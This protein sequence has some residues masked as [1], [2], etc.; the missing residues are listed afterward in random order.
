MTKEIPHVTVCVCTYKRPQFLKRLLSELERQETEGLFSYSVV[1]VD[2]DH[3]QSAN[4]VVSE[5]RSTSSLEIDY[6]VE[7]QQNIALARNKAVENAKG[8]FIAFIDDDEFPTKDWLATLLKTCVEETVDGVLGPVLP[9]FDIEPPAW[10][11]EG[12]FCDRPR[13]QTGSIIDWT[14]GRTGNLLFSKRL[15][16]GETN[17]FRAQFSGGGEDRD[18]FRRWISTGRRFAWCDEAIVYESVPAVRWKRSFM[19]RRALL[20]GKMSLCHSQSHTAN[21]F[22]SFVAVPIYV[23]ALPFLCLFGHHIFMKYLVSLFDHIGRLLA[24]LGFQ[25]VKETYVTE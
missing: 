15:L 25:P 24:W 9:H 10:V 23:L 19:L 3:R 5:C 21:L 20:R 1:V 2:N 7:P 11:K 17:L 16:D 18:L 6:C 4:D 8:D 12:R 22:R 13:H 14:E